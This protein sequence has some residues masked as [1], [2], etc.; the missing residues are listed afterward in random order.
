LLDIVDTDTGWSVVVVFADKVVQPLGLALDGKL[1]AVSKGSV[2]SVI[3]EEIVEYRSRSWLL[4]P[5][6]LEESKTRVGNKGGCN[7]HLRR[8]LIL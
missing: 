6:D 8:R 7:S 2:K 5:D 1:V 3:E 4:V